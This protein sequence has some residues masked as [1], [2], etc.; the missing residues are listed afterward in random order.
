M[1]VSCCLTDDSS[2]ALWILASIRW[3][4]G[5]IVLRSTC[6]AAPSRYASCGWKSC[7]R[8]LKV[9]TSMMPTVSSTSCWYLAWTCWIQEIQEMHTV[10]WQKFWN[11]SAVFF[12]EVQTGLIPSN[13]IRW[14]VCSHRNLCCILVFLFH[15]VSHSRQPYIPRKKR[16]SH[17]LWRSYKQRMNDALRRRR[18]LG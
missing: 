16:L 2:T 10:A 14:V 11:G 3:N 1:Y 17:R 15:T 9:S 12:Q 7:N 6:S 13:I 4:W 8:A 18:N 5:Q